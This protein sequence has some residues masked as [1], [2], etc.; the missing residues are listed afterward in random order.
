MRAAA[1]SGESPIR[2]RASRN[3]TA[4]GSVEYKIRSEAAWTTY[5][6]AGESRG[7]AILLGTRK[8]AGLDGGLRRI[9]RRNVEQSK[10]LLFFAIIL[11]AGPS[12]APFG[13]RMPDETENLDLTFPDCL[14]MKDLM[15]GH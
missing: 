2:S 14:V 8:D 1:S 9:H 10:K 11:D 5:G 15:N 6:T 13:F 12:V 4:Y 7:S 3:L